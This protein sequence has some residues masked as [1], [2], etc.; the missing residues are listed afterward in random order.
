LKTRSQKRLK[1]R[2]SAKRKIKSWKKKEKWRCWFMTRNAKR[3][4]KKSL[5]KKLK[6]TIMATK[7]T[8]STSLNLASDKRSWKRKQSFT[9][10]KSASR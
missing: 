6:M 3:S 4:S 2:K 10:S 9:Q 1:S 8:N 5:R 7:R